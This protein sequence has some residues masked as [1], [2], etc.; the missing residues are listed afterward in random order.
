MRGYEFE[1]CIVCGAVRWPDEMVYHREFEGMV[2][3]FGDHPRI[4]V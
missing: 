4:A 2:C 1:Q 3:M